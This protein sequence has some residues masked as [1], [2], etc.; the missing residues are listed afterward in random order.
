MSIDFEAIIKSAMKDGANAEDLAKGFTEAMNAINSKEKEKSERALWI[1]GKF[2]AVAVEL[3]EGREDYDTAAR[4]LAAVAAEK[5]PEWDLDTCKQFFESVR[6]FIP[7]TIKTFNEFNDGLDHLMS[8][9]N[10][11]KDKARRGAERVAQKTKPVIETITDRDK[12]EAFLE[13][14][15]GIK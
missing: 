10:K 13:E 3:D 14:I 12:I 8:I 5:N 4:F 15:F 2:E 9:L 11:S 7:E 1:E 6:E